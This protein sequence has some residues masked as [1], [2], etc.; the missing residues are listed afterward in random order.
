MDEQIAKQIGA[1]LLCI[2]FGLSGWLLPYRWNILRFRRVLR[3]LLP[4]RVNQ[5][6][7]K[8]VGTVLTV[9]GAIVVIGTVL[10]GKFE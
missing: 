1:G 9:A 6:V 3:S 4:E 8:V 5:L 7:P 2:V 10:F